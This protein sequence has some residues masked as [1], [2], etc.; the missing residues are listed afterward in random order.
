MPKKILQGA[1]GTKADLQCDTMVQS[2]D[3]WGY[4]MGGGGGR[5][6]DKT[7]ACFGMQCRHV[8]CASA[9]SCTS[10]PACECEASFTAPPG[11]LC[12]HPF[13]WSLATVLLFAHRLVWQTVVHCTH[14]FALSQKVNLIFLCGLLQCLRFECSAQTPTAG[15]LGLET[16]MQ[17]YY[18]HRPPLSFSAYSPCASRT[19]G[20]L[21]AWQSPTA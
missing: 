19:L 11:A 12:R 21:R 10:A 5:S 17:C 9:A 15:T 3:W 4:Y 2:R 18:P 8:A 7:T 1:E 14:Q 20:S 16:P 13:C 6:L